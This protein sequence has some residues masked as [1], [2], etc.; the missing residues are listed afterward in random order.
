VPVLA[1]TGSN[2]GTSPVRTS[3]HTKGWGVVRAPSRC[4]LQL[5]LEGIGIDCAGSSASREEDN[6]GDI[7][8]IWSSPRGVQTGFIFL[9][10]GSNL[11]RWGSMG[12]R[13]HGGAMVAH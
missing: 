12:G 11:S 7:L 8:G 4:L 9:W 2:A 5:G 6:L 10:F 1:V 13:S 3:V